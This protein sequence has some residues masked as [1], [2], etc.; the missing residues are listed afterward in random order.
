MICR[1]CASG[2]ESVG[3][4]ASALL[5][6]GLL[7]IR[8]SFV[9]GSVEGGSRGGGRVEVNLEDVGFGDLSLCARLGMHDK[10]V[11]IVLEENGVLVVGDRSS[12][13]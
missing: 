9:H 3:S 10:D 4:V 1:A 5:E 6:E 2:G 7:A 8:Q 13:S 11:L 12:R